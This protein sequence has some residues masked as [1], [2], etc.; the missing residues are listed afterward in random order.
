MKTA[1]QQ[2]FVQIVEC[3]V[4]ENDWLDAKLYLNHSI[5][6]GRVKDNLGKE[7]WQAMHSSVGQ[8]TFLQKKTPR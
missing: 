7:K 2:P 5:F 3:Q 8:L 1:S 4:H 6:M